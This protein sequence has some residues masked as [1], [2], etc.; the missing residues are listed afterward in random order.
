MLV[1]VKSARAV[2][3]IHGDYGT[4]TE[5]AF[6]LKSGIPVIGLNTW[7]IARKGQED[8]SIIQAEERCRRCGESH[9]SGQRSKVV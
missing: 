4:L 2:I 1:V 3:A 9:F 7:S 8:K 5:I 6:A